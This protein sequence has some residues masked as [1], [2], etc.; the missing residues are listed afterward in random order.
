MSKSPAQCVVF[1]SE[2]VGR[3]E[4]RGLAVLQKPISL[5]PFASRVLELVLISLR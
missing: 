3:V 4:G 1:L 2:D 5:L